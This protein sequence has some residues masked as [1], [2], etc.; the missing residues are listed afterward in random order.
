MS[1]T[2]QDPDAEL[3]KAAKLNGNSAAF[4]VADDQF[5]GMTLR[6]WYAGMAMQGLVKSYN[7]EG[8]EEPADLSVQYADA[9]LLALAR[10]K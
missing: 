5:A 9:L 8:P 6:E 7:F 10:N 1:E 3:R 4:P 2:I